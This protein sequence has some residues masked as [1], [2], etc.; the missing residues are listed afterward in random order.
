MEVAHEA[1]IAKI[2]TMVEIGIN[3][4]NQENSLGVMEL[5]ASS[6]RQAAR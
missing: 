2:S 3:S 5:I 6:W 1:T 4:I